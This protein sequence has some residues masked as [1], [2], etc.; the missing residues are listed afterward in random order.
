MNQMKIW[1]LFSGL[2]H[3]LIWLFNDVPYAN[4]CWQCGVDLPP[5]FV[6]DLIDLFQCI[7]FLKLFVFFLISV[8]F[9][10]RRCV[11]SYCQRWHVPL[12][13][14]PLFSSPIIWTV[15]VQSLMCRNWYSWTSVMDVVRHNIEKWYRSRPILE[16][17][18]RYFW[19]S[20]PK[21]RNFGDFSMS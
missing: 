20:G 4:L 10:L 7:H 3:I 19:E 5:A 8:S 21:L 14:G 2:A 17:S 6:C 9:V 12:S 18:K 15:N 11:S 13:S 1:H 16:Q